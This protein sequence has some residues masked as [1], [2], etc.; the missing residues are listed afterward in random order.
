MSPLRPPCI[1]WCWS[2]PVNRRRRTMNRFAN[3]HV[4]WMRWRVFARPRYRTFVNPVRVNVVTAWVMRPRPILSLRRL[5]RW[6]LIRARDWASRPRWVASFACDAPSAAVGP[7]VRWDTTCAGDPR[8]RG[9]GPHG[10][11]PG[12]RS[13][14]RCDG[15]PGCTRRRT[16]WTR[17]VQPVDRQSRRL[18]IAVDTSRFEQWFDKCV[19]V[20]HPRSGVGRR[21]AQPVK[22]G[23]HGSGFDGRA[24]V[25][26]QNRPPP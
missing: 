4:T 13:G 2:Y 22:H 11:V 5:P 25:A 24:V 7:R 23:Q 12:L 16:H 6:R 19:V 8:C 14:S 10:A 9:Q 18:G 17:L 1:Q 3:A 15:G 20:T 26:V 21:D